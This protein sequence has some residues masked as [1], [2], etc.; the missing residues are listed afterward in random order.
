LIVL[1]IIFA[2]VT[3]LLVW[4]LTYCVKNLIQPRGARLEGSVAVVL[5]LLAML[6]AAGCSVGCFMEYRRDLRCD[7]APWAQTAEGMALYVDWVHDDS[8]RALIQTPD[9]SREY[10]LVEEHIAIGDRVE[11]RRKDAEGCPVLVK[12]SG[13]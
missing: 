3:G 2:I 1:S 4:F 13:H 8:T 5:V 11:M 6:V 12:R 7:P 9:G 10:H